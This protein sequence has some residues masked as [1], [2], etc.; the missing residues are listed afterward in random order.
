[1]LPSSLASPQQHAFQSYQ[2]SSQGLADWMTSSFLPPTATNSPS[3]QQPYASSS[4]EVSSVFSTHPNAHYAQQPLQPP[5]QSTSSHLSRFSVMPTKPPS[6]AMPVMNTPPSL[7]SLAHDSQQGS[8]GGAGG[9]LSGLDLGHRLGGP[10][11]GFGIGSSVV[12][13]SSRNGRGKAGTG[14]GGQ[15]S[16]K[17]EG[18]LKAVTDQVGY[19]E[20]ESGEP[21]LKLYYYRVVRSL[22]LLASSLLGFLIFEEIFVVRTPVW[23]HGHPPRYQ[24]HLPQA[25]TASAST[26]VTLERALD[27]PGRARA[28][29]RP[30]G[31][32]V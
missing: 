16:E 13:G 10:S 21:Y 7:A 12:G 2:T 23:Q 26:N 31:R 8:S 4:S 17:Q 32:P 5:S 25:S 24:S 30:A 6:D 1:M 18:I 27:G 15:S 19:L 11:G 20:G 3:Q 22:R 14:V 29:V 28:Q 9:R